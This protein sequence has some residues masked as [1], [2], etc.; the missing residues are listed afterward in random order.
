MIQQVFTGLIQSL[1]AL[2]QLDSTRL[3]I[4]CGE[5]G[6]VTALHDI[7]VGDSISVDG[8]C[9]TVETPLDRGF[10]ATASPETLKRT[11]LGNLK[12]GSIVN[13]ESSL[14]VGSKIGGHFVTGHVDGQGVLD[15]AI[16]TG[17]SWELRFLVPDQ[18]VAKYIVEKGSVA[19]N[20]IS[21]TIANC[22]PHGD[23][24]TVSVIPVTYAETGLKNLLIHQSV[25]L[26]G[27]ILGKY[28]EKFLHLEDAGSAT[29]ER[30]AAGSISLDFLAENGY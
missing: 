1:G 24:F 28:A 2:T 16:A 25:N 3:R 18:R 8:V 12:D 21:L 11:T 9:L 13:L 6:A 30:A 15:S 14:R 7:A 20:G 26:E 27:D 10:I 17:T 23:W 4:D 19:V 5:L 29:P 22:S